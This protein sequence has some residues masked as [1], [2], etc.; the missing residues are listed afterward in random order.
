MR[1]VHF[2]DSPCA[3]CVSL[4]VALGCQQLTWPTRL[5]ISSAAELPRRH[6]LYVPPPGC[7]GTSET[8]LT[9]AL[10]RAAAR[11]SDMRQRRHAI[12]PG[13]LLLSAAFVGAAG[14][15]ALADVC[16]PSSIL[17]FV[18][19]FPSRGIPGEGALGCGRLGEQGFGAA[20]VA[21]C[22]DAVDRL[23][24]NRCL[25]A[26]EVAPLLRQFANSFAAAAAASL[27]V[28]GRSLVVGLECQIAMPPEAVVS[29]PFSA[30]APAPTEVEALPAPVQIA[31][32]PPPPPPQPSKL[33]ACA[34]VRMLALVTDLGCAGLAI[35]GTQPDASA[36]FANSTVCCAALSALDAKRCFC[37]AD[38]FATV[39]SDAA[40]AQA[41]MLMLAA[42]PR[43]CRVGVHVGPA[44]STLQP[45][46]IDAILGALP[47]VS[48]AAVPAPAPAPALAPAQAPSAAEVAIADVCTPL[49]VVSL[50]VT[51]RCDRLGAQP[52]DAAQCCNQ[53]ALLN[54]AH[55]FCREL[56]LALLD[57]F[58][59][60]F[61]AILEAAA[62]VCAVSI[63]GGV[64]CL[65][66]AEE[67]P[68]VQPAPPQGPAPGSPLLAPVT[69]EQGAP[70][71]STPQPPV[72][73]GVPEEQQPLP[74][75]TP[76]STITFAP[77]QIRAASPPASHGVP[78]SPA[79]ESPPKPV[80]SVPASTPP[81][82][83][84]APPA[85][86]GAPVR[87]AV[88]LAQMTPEQ[89]R[90]PPSPSLELARPSPPPTEL[91]FFTRYS[92]PPPPKPPSSASPLLQ[93]AFP[94]AAAAVEVSPPPQR[95]AVPPSPPLPSP[96]VVLRSPPQQP[97]FSPPPPMPTVARMQEPPSPKQ[98][99]AVSTNQGPAPPQLM[100]AEPPLPLSSPPMELPLFPRRER[101]PPPAQPPA[102]QT[103]QPPF[104]AM[105]L[106]QQAASSPPPPQRMVFT[107]RPL[108]GPAVQLP[109]P[110]SFEP[111]AAQLPPP[112]LGP[113]PVGRGGNAFLGAPAPARQLPRPQA[114]LA[115]PTVPTAALPSP[116]RG[117]PTPRRPPLSPP[118]V[119]G[120]S[121]L[122]GGQSAATLEALLLASIEAAS[123]TK[124]E[125]LL[126]PPL[127]FSPEELEQAGAPA[128]APGPLVAPGPQQAAKQLPRSACT[129]ALV[130]APFTA[131][132]CGLLG[133]DG[134]SVDATAMC[135]GALAALNALRCLC[136]AEHASALRRMAGD[137]GVVCVVAPVVCGFRIIV[138]E[139]CAVASAPT[140]LPP[141]RTTTPP[142][143]TMTAQPVLM[144]PTQHPPVNLPAVPPP[145]PNYP[146]PRPPERPP[147]SPAHLTQK[148]PPAPALRPP[149]PPPL[150][151][152]RP[153]SLPT[154]FTQLPRVQQPINQAVLIGTE[155]EVA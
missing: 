90:S 113:P 100:P 140:L 155:D 105:Q 53:L 57:A 23:S 116:E 110:A 33:P 56:V 104:V 84:E 96:E 34:P 97:A 132:G 153:P 109:P 88:P 66:F 111:P 139:Q 45:A 49:A 117:T 108:S 141:R 134:F 119:P 22:C 46:A 17:A 24:D 144:A 67:A 74:A 65:P 32:P 123:T 149:A 13:A 29:L 106:P 133:T 27:T 82:Q 103:F 83:V 10:C 52:F 63:R 129:A 143:P 146:T 71:Q 101:P 54:E 59:S 2:G 86:V 145:S 40:L 118:P 92:R 99:A 142:A 127:L 91:P 150:P 87:P 130:A 7:A 151:P 20:N 125:L 26:P 4:P 16:A 138:A 44:C 78:A 115:A 12:A 75:A 154:I 95:A 5:A 55:C 79:P 68:A 11:A 121:I 93:P 112:A 107:E 50:V 6:Q 1:G 43:A 38:H 124:A 60:S 72:R 9:R 58:Q 85:A 77:K 36:G 42:A 136:A 73:P 80:A 147:S 48:P 14:E 69:R 70:M 81:A 31:Q 35:A 51:L 122:E 61:G 148:P 152:P 120:A 131:M 39:E 15:T 25:C 62:P 135:C 37:R 8:L 47:L 89:R 19:A 102:G 64:A 137:V 128:Q 18:A 98:V 3:R 28:C 30:P 94:P 21:R 76:T 126:L 41:A 114:P